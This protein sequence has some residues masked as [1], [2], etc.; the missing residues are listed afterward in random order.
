MP[1]TLPSLR[2][3][4][5]ERLNTPAYVIFRDRLLQNLDSM[6][7]VAKSPSRL[8]PHCKTHKMGQIIRLWIERGVTKH[9]AATIAECEM[10]AAAGATDVLFAYNPVG[11]NVGRLV[12]LAKTFPACRFTA[13]TDH[14]QPLRAL[15]AAAAAAFAAAALLAAFADA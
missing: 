1:I 13:T 8:R 7:R 12:T 14:E 3:D 6:I 2:P 10:C 9:K 15:S 11:P 4:E 5:L